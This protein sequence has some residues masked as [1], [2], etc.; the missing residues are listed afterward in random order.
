MAEEA[1]DGRARYWFLQVG[2]LDERAAAAT[3]QRVRRA[4]GASS[5]VE[6]L[7]FRRW[8]ARAMDDDTVR[9]ALVVLQAGLGEASVPPDVRQTVQGLVSDMQFW[10]ECEFSDE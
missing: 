5:S 4:V 10:L 8:Y 7:D 3:V 6:L 9:D 1:S 2:P